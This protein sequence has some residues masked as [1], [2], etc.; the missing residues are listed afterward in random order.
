[1][2]GGN[3][4]PLTSILDRSKN[5]LD[6]IRLFAAIWVVWD[7]A[8]LISPEPEG[9]DLSAPG[10]VVP[11]FGFISGLVITNSL[12][13]KDRPLDFLISVFC[14]LYIPLTMVVLVSAFVLAPCVSSL[15]FGE[16]YSQ[17]LYDVLKYVR[18]NLTFRLE[19]GIP[20]VFDNN[21]F[22]L[23]LNG[24]LWCI[25]YFFGGYL[26]LLSLKLIGVLRPHYK[27]GFFLLILAFGFLLC[28]KICSQVQILPAAHN[29]VTVFSIV[30]GA[31]ICS[32]K[33]H[34]PCNY[35][36]PLAALLLKLTIG[37]WSPEVMH[38]CNIVFI[39]AL[40]V[41]I[42]H[43]SWFLRLR[44]RYNLSLGYFLMSFPVQQ[45]LAYLFVTSPIINFV[46]TVLVTGALAIVSHL[47][48][49]R[50]SYSLAAY[51]K[52]KVAKYQ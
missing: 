47:T 28:Q 40:A 17:H 8:F 20:T 19:Y 3:S 18:R 33:Y 37:R 44:P 5:N 12:L 48:I 45:T 31:A 11:L 13:N 34:L 36:L 7:H 1:M 9:Y 32:L 21:K 52:L 46:L 6:L 38:I 16:F 30:F 14:R 51:L 41:W 42:S 25:T 29:I 35:Y 43:Q 49:E 50:F 23:Y 4:I 26:F 27:T 24:N 15:S 22:K 10:Y 39:F 2:G